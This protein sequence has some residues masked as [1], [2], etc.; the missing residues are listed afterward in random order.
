MSVSRRD[1]IRASYRQ[2]GG[3]FAGAFSRED[4]A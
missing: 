1:E 4:D 2:L 3:A